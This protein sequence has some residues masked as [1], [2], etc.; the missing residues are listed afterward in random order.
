MRLLVELSSVIVGRVLV[1]GEVGRGD[2]LRD[3][4]MIDEFVFLMIS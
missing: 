2:M 1:L 3:V 4:L